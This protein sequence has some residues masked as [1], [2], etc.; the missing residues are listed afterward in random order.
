MA[1]NPRECVRYAGVL[2]LFPLTSYFV[3]SGAYRMRP[4][5]PLIVILACRAILAVIPKRQIVRI[6]IPVVQ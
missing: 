6:R 2:F 4:L 1:R 5:D 3:H